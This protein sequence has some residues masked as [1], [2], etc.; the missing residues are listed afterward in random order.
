MI[1]DAMMN[2]TAKE[3]IEILNYCNPVFLSKIPSIV[4][5]D[6]KKLAETSNK[7][8]KIDKTK[9][10]VEQNILEESKDFISLLYYNYIADEEEKEEILKI[11]KENEV[12]YNKISANKRR[13][14]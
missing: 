1:G 13:T 3:T 12:A 5:T 10:L 2:D 9:K 14:N 6:L 11:W 7:I 8:V 4:L